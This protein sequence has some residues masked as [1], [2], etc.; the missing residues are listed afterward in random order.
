M[1]FCIVSIAVASSTT[2]FSYFLIIFF[3]VLLEFIVRSTFKQ[4]N[5]QC[6]TSSME[7]MCLRRVAALISY[8]QVFYAT[9]IHIL[10]WQHSPTAVQS[11]WNRTRE[12]A[13]DLLVHFCWC[14]HAYVS[15]IVPIAILHI[16]IIVIISCSQKIRCL[17]VRCATTTNLCR[18][19]SIEFVFATLRQ[20][21]VPFIE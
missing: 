21:V 18:R 20:F 6:S 19:V 8:A 11:T 13:N 14:F 5:R 4:V 7:W 15:S 10:K 3:R 12:I 9:I 1:S 16:I 2:S 17:F